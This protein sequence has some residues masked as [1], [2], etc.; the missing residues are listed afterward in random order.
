MRID[1]EAVKQQTVGRWPGILDTLGIEVG[2]GKHCAC[3]MCGGED[4]FRFDDREGRGTWFCNYC[5]AGDGFKIVQE[6]LTIDFKEAITEI[7]KII[8][9]IPEG[10]I[11]KEKT[12]SPDI[13][14]KIFTGSKPFTATDTVGRYLFNRGLEVSTD[15]IRFHPKCYEPETGEK[16]PTML[17]V[18][19]MPNDEAV[20]IH[21]T[22]LSDLSEKAD[23]KEPKKLM[24]ALKKMS[25]G[26]IRLFDPTEEG[27]VGLAEG[28]ET[29]LAVRQMMNIPCWSSVSSTLMEKFEP[30][31]N[32]KHL[33]IFSDND[34]NYAGQK[35]SFILANRVIIQKKI[36]ASVYIP[37]KPGTDFLDE[38]NERG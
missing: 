9:N 33:H 1:F 18:F 15:K 2:H 32:I 27:H 5:G 16:I 14:R 37:D 24:P 17:A 29:A 8:G 20:T 31:K 7:A 26:A 25:G 11:R 38:L 34:F 6:V 22:F 12:I 13:L 3:P 35:A 21:R 19:I 30:P 4:R 10:Q 36:K 28:I 23:I